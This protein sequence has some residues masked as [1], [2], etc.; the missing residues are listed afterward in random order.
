MRIAAQLASK[1]H[2]YLQTKNKPGH[3]SIIQYD[4]TQINVFPVQIHVIG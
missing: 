3:I 1:E 2:A 4:F